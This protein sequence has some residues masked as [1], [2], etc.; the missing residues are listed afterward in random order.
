MAPMVEV[1]NPA[2]NK[3]P[4]AGKDLYTFGSYSGQAFPNL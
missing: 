3:N 2:F 4:Y 1:E